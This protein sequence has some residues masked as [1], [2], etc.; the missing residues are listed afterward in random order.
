M[1]RITSLNQ[2]KKL[3][4]YNYDYEVIW[5]NKANTTYDIKYPDQT[6]EEKAEGVW[7]WCDFQENKIYIDLTL[8]GDNPARGAE[9]LLHEMIHAG[10]DFHG[11][12]DNSTEEEY[13]ELSAKMIIA[14]FRD[15]Y[16]EMQFII[17]LTTGKNP[18]IPKKKTT[19]KSKKNT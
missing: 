5:T 9:V 6:E 3:K 17:S 13:T 12:T 19:K 14:F 16:S 18:I 4:I 2:I 1:K 7:G 10:H 8:T 15:N 11:L